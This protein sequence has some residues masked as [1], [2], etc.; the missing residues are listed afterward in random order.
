MMR[1]KPL[2]EKTRSVANI[3]SECTYCFSSIEEESGVFDTLV[4]TNLT[5]SRLLPKKNFRE[6]FGLLKF[7]VRSPSHIVRSPV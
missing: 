3:S 4:H 5:L 7:K 2:Y 6:P 1:A